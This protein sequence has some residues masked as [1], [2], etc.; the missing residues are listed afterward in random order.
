[1]DR[2]SDG[3]MVS[4]LIARRGPVLV[5]SIHTRERTADRQ[6]LPELPQMV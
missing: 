1:M 2:G 6:F 5:A 3:R 4:L